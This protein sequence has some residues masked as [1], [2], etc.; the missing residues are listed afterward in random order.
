MGP[1]GSPGSR[2]SVRCHLLVEGWRGGL[3]EEPGKEVSQQAG[4]GAG[5]GGTVDSGLQIPALCPGSHNSSAEN[6]L[7]I[8]A[9]RGSVG[10]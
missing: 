2:E 4:G 6:L 5:G 3:A 1:Q 10:A 8:G 9:E 7:R